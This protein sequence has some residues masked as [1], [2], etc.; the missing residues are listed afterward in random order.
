V[1][2]M[3]DANSININVNILFLLVILPL[4][5]KHSHVFCLVHSKWWLWVTVFLFHCSD[6]KCMQ[7]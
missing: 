3:C 1:T 2:Q 5:P 6:M 4:L 7:L